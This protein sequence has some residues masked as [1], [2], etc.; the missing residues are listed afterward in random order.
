MYENLFPLNV[1]VIIIASFT[2]EY[3]F[4]ITNMVSLHNQGG[5]IFINSLIEAPRLNFKL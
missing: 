4:F 1:A 2:F 3:I 5:S